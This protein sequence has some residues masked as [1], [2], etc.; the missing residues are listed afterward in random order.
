MRLFS[1]MVWIWVSQW[2]MGL[3]KTLQAISFLSYL[4]VHRKSPGPFCELRKPVVWLIK[5]EC[6]EISV[7]DLR[8]PFFWGCF[9]C[10]CSGTVSS[11]CYRWLGFRDGQIH[12][13]TEG[14]QVCRRQRTP[15]QSTQSIV[16]TCKR[17]SLINWCEFW[18]L[19]I[20]SWI[21][22]PFSLF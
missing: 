2:Q 3:G 14:S 7:T 18:N 15:A 10:C 1:T 9:C 11:K 21:Q 20:L 4:K 17:A 6:F 8:W 19:A 22:F 12:S 5:F 16:W 13:K